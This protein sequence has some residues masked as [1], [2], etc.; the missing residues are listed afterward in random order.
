MACERV[1]IVVGESPVFPVGHFLVLARFPFVGERLLSSRRNVAVPMGIKA[2]CL[3]ER[4]VV[5]I[6]SGAH[7]QKPVAKFAVV[8]LTVFLPLALSNVASL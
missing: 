7:S 4:I 2:E 6:L 5:G 1:H 3:I 8:M